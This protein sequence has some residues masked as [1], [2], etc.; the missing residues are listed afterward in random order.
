[1]SDLPP[2]VH[3]FVDIA[4]EKV[5]IASHLSYLEQRIVALKAVFIT[6]QRY[7]FSCLTSSTIYM[8]GD[9]AGLGDSIRVRCGEIAEN[10]RLLETDSE[11]VT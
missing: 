5:S 10:W 3:T 6:S 9:I 11:Q 1:M 4:D 8:A 2:Q 7:R